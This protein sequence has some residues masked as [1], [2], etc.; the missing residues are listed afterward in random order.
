[1]A[2]SN[3]YKRLMHAPGSIAWRRRNALS[4]PSD[5]SFSSESILPVI[6]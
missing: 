3:P 2:P 1:M 6:V 4:L 5:F